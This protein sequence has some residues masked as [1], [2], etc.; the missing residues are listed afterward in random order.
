MSTARVDFTRGA[1]ERI[2]SVVRQVEQGNRNGSPLTFRRV[3]TVE[4]RTGPSIRLA[5]GSGSWQQGATQVLTLG[6]YTTG[7]TVVVTNAMM[8]L[9]AKSRQYMIGRDGTAAWYLLNWQQDLQYAVTAAELGATTL[10]LK[11]VGVGAVGG[12]ETITVPVST[13]AT[14]TT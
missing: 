14:A 3:V 9:P 1:A 13:C 4:P 5:N 12:N 8:S 11:A 6:S 7:E 10:D 2:A